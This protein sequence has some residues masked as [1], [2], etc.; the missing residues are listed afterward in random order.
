[1]TVGEFFTKYQ[2]ADLIDENIRNEAMEFTVDKTTS[3][4]VGL[5]LRTG[6][7]MVNISRSY[8]RKFGMTDTR[9]GLMSCEI[10]VR[11]PLAHF[12]Y[13]NK[14]RTAI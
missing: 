12:H 13:E 6:L 9:Y 11:T 8:W 5:G 3:T 14:K 2:N 7:R 1:M 4:M 10:E